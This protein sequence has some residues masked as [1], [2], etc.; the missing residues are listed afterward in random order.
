[1][2]SVNIS[3][4]KDFAQLIND[5]PEFRD[6]MQG[7]FRLFLECDKKFTPLVD[8]RTVLTAFLSEEQSIRLEGL[9]P[10]DL[11]PDNDDEPETDLDEI[12]AQ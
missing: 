6:Y 5:S 10:F 8:G 2:T 7:L 12:E 3:D 11:E 4:P 1:M 9:E